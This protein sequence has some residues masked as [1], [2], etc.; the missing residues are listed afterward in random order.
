[1][2]TKLRPLSGL[3]IYSAFSPLRQNA[4]AGSEKKKTGQGICPVRKI[5]IC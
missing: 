3:L 2:Q 5:E 1:M 4:I